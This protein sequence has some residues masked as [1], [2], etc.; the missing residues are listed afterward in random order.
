MVLICRKTKS[1]ND[2]VIPNSLSS[3]TLGNKVVV[4][5]EKLNKQLQDLEIVI[6]YTLQ[7]IVST[8]YHT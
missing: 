2:I 5:S 8:L 4:Q 6:N 3:Q 7:E 1:N